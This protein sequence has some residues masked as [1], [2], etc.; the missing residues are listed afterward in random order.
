[1]D[2][3]NLDIYGHEPI[4]WS[5][6]LRQLEAHARDLTYHTPHRPDVVVAARDAAEV[7]RVLA[8][9]NAKRIPVVPFGAGTSLEGHTIPVRGGIVLELSGLG[10]IAIDAGDLQATVGA[11]PHPVLEEIV[12]ARM[13]RDRG[14]LQC[15]CGLDGIDDHHIGL[16]LLRLRKDPLHASFGEEKNIRRAGDQHAVAQHANPQRRIDVAP[17]IENRGLVSAPIAIGVFE[18]DDPVALRPKPRLGPLPI[19]RPLT[20]PN[21][22]PGIHIDITRIDQ[23]RLGRE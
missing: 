22:S 20:N 10:G 17:L 16:Q 12:L 14:N 15:V 8:Y 3:Q 11:G 21:P 6:A 18:D 7:S 1:M 5:R 2:E 23:H 13:L 9:A 4:P 19:V